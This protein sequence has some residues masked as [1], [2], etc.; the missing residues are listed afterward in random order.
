MLQIKYL[1]QLPMEV[2]GNVG[3]LLIDLIERVAD[4]SPPKVAKSISTGFPQ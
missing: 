3:Y 2:I 1:I 4:Y